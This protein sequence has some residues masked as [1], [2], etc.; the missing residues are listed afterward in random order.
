MKNNVY[1]PKI[2]GYN[3]TTEK[4]EVIKAYT[5][6]EGCRFNPTGSKFSFCSEYNYHA[7]TGKPCIRYSK[8][9]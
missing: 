2:L 6:C 3:I 8:R 9:G 7:L 4:I 1:I 5:V